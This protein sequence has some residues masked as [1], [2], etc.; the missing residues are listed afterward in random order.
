M[1][2]LA[3]ILFSTALCVFVAFRA[4]EMDRRVPWFKRAPAD[5]RGP[6]PVANGH[7]RG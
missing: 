2:D 5:E 1:L 7:R 3:S 4:L 6:E